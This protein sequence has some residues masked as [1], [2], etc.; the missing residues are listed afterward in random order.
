M[1][2]PVTKLAKPFAIT[3]KATLVLPLAMPTYV[4]EA[5]FGP[6]SLTVITIGW[7][8]LTTALAMSPDVPAAPWNK[9]P[10]PLAG[11]GTAMLPT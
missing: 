1:V 11:I 9:L 5:L 3:G 8:L 6:L 2:V 4:P 10:L 7:S